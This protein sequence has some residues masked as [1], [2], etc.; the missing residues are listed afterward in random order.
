MP[1]RSS[2]PAQPFDGY[3]ITPTSDA[4]RR[5]LRAV[6]APSQ[7]LLETLQILRAPRRGLSLGTRD[8]AALYDAVEPAAREL[9]LP[10]PL[11]FTPM[12]R[13]PRFEAAPLSAFELLHLVHEGFWGA[14]RGREAALAAVESYGAQPVPALGLGALPRRAMRTAAERHV[15]TLIDREPE[16]RHPSERLFA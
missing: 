16:L 13:G 9:G 1:R 7:A 6:H 3:R 5:S 11:R 12:R 4:A 14:V 2:Q 8:A 10:F 15:D